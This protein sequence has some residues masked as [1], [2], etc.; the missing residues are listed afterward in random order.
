MSNNEY[1]FTS[2]DVEKWVEQGL[3]TP[4]QETSIRTYLESSGSVEEQ[5]LG[6]PEQRKGLNFI[7][8]AYYFGS[9]MI[10][11]AYTI[12]MGLE[13]ET[14]GFPLQ[15]T[16]SLGTIGVLWALGFL[17]RKKGFQIAGGLLVFAGTG[18]VPLLVTTVQRALG[19]WPETEFAYRD[20]YRVVAQTWV[21]LEL[22]SILVTLI[23]I[24]LV[25]FPLLT[26]LIAFW[27]W[28]L[29]MDLTR[30]ITQSNSWSWT[31]V[32]QTVSA[33]MGAGMLLLGVFLQRRAKQDYSSWFYLF[34]HLIILGFFSSLAIDREGILGLVYFVVYLSFVVA[35]VWLQRR[36]F[37][38]FGAFGCYG[39]LS[40]L[41]FQVFDGEMGFVFAL[42]GIGLL[43]VLSAVAYQKYAR[44][45]LE[46]QFA[47]RTLSTAKS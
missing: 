44:P 4:E 41:A 22:I 47:Q 42:A 30:W 14:M 32:E 28:F 18:I 6:I 38:V 46:R 11:L 37:L 45:W 26:L 5:S 27:M 10:L 31:D 39:Y 7:S 40:Y 8:L 16:V 25:R 9:F 12:F 1:R 29:S 24:W 19:L 33:I 21:P 23:M 36:V 17:L 34:G 3:I 35:S 43:I 20:F 15:I 2:A 13:W